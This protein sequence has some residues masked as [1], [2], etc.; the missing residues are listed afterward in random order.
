VPIDVVYPHYIEEAFEVK[1]SSKQ[2]WYY[3]SKCRPDDVVLL[4]VFDNA[5]DGR[6]FCKSVAN[7]LYTICFLLFST[8]GV[9]HGAFKDPSASENAMPRRSIEIRA[10]VFG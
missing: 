10:M 7:S 4:K 6:A 2:K 5:T 1:P 8:K 9:A 3:L